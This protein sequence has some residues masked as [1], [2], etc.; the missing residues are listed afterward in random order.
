[1][2]YFLSFASPLTLGEVRSMLPPGVVADLAPGPDQRALK[3]IHPTALTVG[4]L[5]I[6]RC[7]CDL[8]RP[9]LP[10]P[11]EDERHLRERYRREGVSR[12]ETIAAL[13]RHRRSGRPAPA[14]RDWPRLLASFVAEH[15]RN[16][17]P[18]LYYLHFSSGPALLGRLGE[19][20]RIDLTQVLAQPETWLEEGAPTLVSRS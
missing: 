12:P 9:R 8:V 3:D 7:S 5:L 15:A 17:G 18:T 16:A 20:R 14:P 1:M 13:E 2:C 4:R 19:P 10:D 6:G 11:R